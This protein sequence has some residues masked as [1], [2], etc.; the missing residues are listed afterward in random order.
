MRRLRALAPGP[1]PE[2][3][4]K[5]DG[6]YGAPHGGNKVRKLEWILPDVEARGRRTIVTVGGLATN[7]GLAT[8]VWGRE[9]GLRTALAL[10]DQPLDDARAQPG[11]AHPALRRTRLPDPRE[12]PHLS[13]GALDTPAPHGSSQPAGCRTSCP[14]EGRPPW[15]A[16]ATSRARSNWRSRSRA[17][18]SPSP[19]TSSWRSG[20]AARRRA[21]PPG[22]GSP[23]CAPAWWA[24]SS[25]TALRSTPGRSRAWPR[26]M[27]LL[28]RRGATWA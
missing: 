28:R 22:F 3:W 15:V 5:D 11:G 19:R 1:G 17:V 20:R 10:V 13:G 2:V 9:R 6:A 18:T 27:A 26:A 8:A 4:L 12:V 21:W 25:T 23:A 7:H 24:W 16:W 14:W